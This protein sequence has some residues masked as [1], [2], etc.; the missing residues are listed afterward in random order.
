M[1]L[2]NMQTLVFA[3]PAMLLGFMVMGFEL[4]G[5]K[6]V[7]YEATKFGIYQYIGVFT[8]FIVSYILVDEFLF[9]FRD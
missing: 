6:M 2:L 3:I 8:V 7:I 1:S 4:E 9:Y 5:I